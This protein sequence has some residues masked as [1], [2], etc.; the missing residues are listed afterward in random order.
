MPYANL[1]GTTPEFLRMFGLKSLNELPSLSDLRDL[2]GL[3][4]RQNL[5]K[6]KD[7]TELHK[8]Q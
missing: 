6:I 4:R 7:T 2:L 3:A 8:N 1:Y 5:K